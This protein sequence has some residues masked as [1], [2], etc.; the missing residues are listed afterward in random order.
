ME[1]GSVSTVPMEVKLFITLWTLG[2]KESFRGVGDWGTA[3]CSPKIRW[4][5]LRPRWEL[6]GFLRRSRWWAPTLEAFER[7]KQP[8]WCVMLQLKSRLPLLALWCQTWICSISGIIQTILRLCC[9]PWP[10]WR[11][12]SRQ[13]NL[14]R[15]TLSARES[16]TKKILASLATQ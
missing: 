14:R 8:T 10:S 16:V 2:N 13:P 7:H 6:A 15:Y 4:R 3:D 11:P 12:H 5:W 9:T 1:S